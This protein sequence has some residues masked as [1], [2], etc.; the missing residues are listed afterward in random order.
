MFRKARLAGGLRAIYVPSGDGV[1][2]DGWLI[3]VP[4][5]DLIT[6]AQVLLQDERLKIAAT[7]PDTAT[8]TA[9]LLHMRVRIDSKA[10]H[11]SY[12]AWRENQY[13]DLV[14]AVAL[15]YWLGENQRRA[16]SL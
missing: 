15:A 9:E 11:D 6:S 3:G 7:L 12:A 5:R 1:T 4:K 10:A 8:L 2:W 13:D 16:Y 14:F